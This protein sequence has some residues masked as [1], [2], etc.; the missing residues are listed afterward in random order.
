MYPRKLVIVISQLAFLALLNRAGY[1]WAH[2]LSLRLPGNLVGMLILLALLSGRL[3]RLEWIQEGASILTRHLA[4][5]CIPIAVGLIGFKEAFLQNG[6]A[7]LGTLIV[8][9][10]AGILLCGFIT[11]AFKEKEAKN[12]ESTAGIIRHWCYRVG[13]RP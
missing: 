1:M 5:F 2:V 12:H 9:A 4:F 11:Q 3:I 13:L 6:L 7:I 10:T 8:S